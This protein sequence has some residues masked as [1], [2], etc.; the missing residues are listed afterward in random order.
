MRINLILLFLILLSSKYTCNANKTIEARS[1]EA[2]DKQVENVIFVSN[3]IEFLGALGNDRKIIITN[4]IYIK[5]DLNDVITDSNKLFVNGD[6][7]TLRA[8]VPSYVG[9]FYTIKAAYSSSSVTKGEFTKNNFA[10]FVEGE[11]ILVIKKVKNLII[12]TNN[13]SSIVIR[14]S[15][16]E[17]IRFEGVTKVKILN[18]NIFHKTETE[19]GCGEFAPVISFHNSNDVTIDNC[20]LNGS[21]TEG[22][23][24]D[25]VK[26]IVIKNTEIF[27]C[28]KRGVSFKNSSNVKLVNCKIHSNNLDANSVYYSGPSIFNLKNSNI[29]VE[30]TQII[31][32]TSTTNTYF[33]DIDD[34]STIKF[35]GCYIADNI[36]FKVTEELSSGLVTKPIHINKTDIVYKQYKTYF[37]SA[38]SG[39]N[40]RKSPK[41]KILGKYPL[42]TK[43][44]VVEYPKVLDEITDNG[45]IIKGEWVGIQYKMDTVYVFNG[46][47]APSRIQTDLKVYFLTS[48]HRDQKGETQTAF[49][50]LSETY[51]ENRGANYSLLE[52]SSI[53][54]N[55]TIRFNKIQRKIFLKKMKITEADSIFI[56]DLDSNK[57][58]TYKVKNL[59]VIACLNIYTDW[60]GSEDDYEF[61]FDLGK[62]KV[63]DNFV[64][65]GNVS[66]FQ[67]D[68]IKQIIWEPIDKKKLP[69]TFSPKIV[70]EEARSWFKNVIPK[71]AYTFSNDNFNYYIQNLEEEEHLI[72]RYL[73]VFDASSQKKVFADIFLE[74]E[75]SYLTP[76]NIKNNNPQSYEKQWTG[77]LFKDKPPVLFGLMDFSFGCSFISFLEDQ[78]PPLR[79]LCDNRH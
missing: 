11:V 58:H 66:P 1:Y 17:V 25:E 30:T 51:F 15:E 29:E 37:V 65:I 71:Q 20:K 50:N 5:E 45:K 33:T 4:D 19:G 42:N 18:L 2:H 79:I 52:N 40:Y 63:G 14:Q 44:T 35:S 47:L 41:G 13:S 60:G 39:L 55:D 9:D 8:G 59:P 12:T 67:N 16:D 34:T 64:A 78:E 23:H 28:N 72:G 38:K 46:F 53:G 7:S 27:N 75:G 57:T 49:V 70:N 21:G 77:R 26:G 56:Y 54:T 68:R 31:S 76:L 22:I 36:N 6:G 3:L 62:V 48:Y 74:S 32:N 73:V 61:G 43:V 10:K 24:T 69:V